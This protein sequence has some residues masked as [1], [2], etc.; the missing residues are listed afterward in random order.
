VAEMHGFDKIRCSMTERRM[1]IAGVV[2]G[3]PAVEC[4]EEGARGSFGMLEVQSRFRS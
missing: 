2:V 1:E 3:E 4:G